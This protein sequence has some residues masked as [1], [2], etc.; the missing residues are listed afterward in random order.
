M[1]TF[2]TDHDDDDHHHHDQLGL[3]N[4]HSLLCLDAYNVNVQ[5]NYTIQLC[6]ALQYYFDTRVVHS[7]QLSIHII[8]LSMSVA[9]K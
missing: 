3:L 5:T 9:T 1:C 4:W 6:A 2:C 7:L 8:C